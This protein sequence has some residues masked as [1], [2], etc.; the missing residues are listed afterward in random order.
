MNEASLMLNFKF[1]KFITSKDKKK[2]INRQASVFKIKNIKLQNILHKMTEENLTQILQK[3]LKITVSNIMIKNLLT[4]V[5]ITHKMMFKSVKSNI[6]NCILN[7]SKIQINS[8]EIKIK[9]SLYFSVNLCAVI[10]IKNVR[11]SV[12]LNTEMK[13]NLIKMKLIKSLK[14]LFT[15]ND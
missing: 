2:I 12:L 5:S 1:M 10:E 9:K 7:L 15:V 11:I 3:I 13:I 6:I 14:I 4:S 8:T